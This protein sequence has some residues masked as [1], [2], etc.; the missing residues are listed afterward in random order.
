MSSLAKTY[1]NEL[2]REQKYLANWLPNN[3][4][5]LGDIGEFKDNCFIVKGNIKNHQVDFETESGDANTDINYSSNGG[6]SI[7]TKLSGTFAP[8]GGSLGEGDAG[9]IVEFSREKAILL[10]TKN[11]KVSRIKDQI[12]LEAKML[13]LFKQNILKSKRAVITEIIYADGATILVS[14]SKSA[15]IE[16]KATA[17]LEKAAMLDI[18]DASFAFDIPFRKDLAAE[19]IT[20]NGFIIFYRVMAVTNGF[21]T[22]DRV[23]SKGGY[24]DG[25]FEARE[26]DFDFNPI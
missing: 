25:E 24:R 19:Y 9:I 22:G 17:K 18:A 15:R 7:S 3:P 13:E 6:V 23:V 16:L 14:N 5:K 8:A 12:T 1:T 20:K 4:I 10:K 26:V 11:T 21:F 2:L